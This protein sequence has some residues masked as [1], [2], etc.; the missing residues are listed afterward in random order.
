MIFEESSLAKLREAMK[1]RLSE[2]RYKHTLGVEDMA[3]YLGS[4]II[5]KKV[6]EL[7][8]AALLHDIDNEMSY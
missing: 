3:K 7:R 2:K 1:M 6:D 5:P 8:A 4:I